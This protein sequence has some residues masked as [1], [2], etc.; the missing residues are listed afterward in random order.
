MQLQMNKSYD[1]KIKECK[2]RIG[3]K[4]ILYII[5]VVIGVCLFW[6][7][8]MLFFTSS[9][10]SEWREVIPTIEGGGSMN[11]TTSTFNISA[12]KWLLYWEPREPNPNHKCFVEIFNASTDEKLGELTLATN[13]QL[14][15]VF[16]EELQIRGSFY[17]K[18]QIM[19]TRGWQI[20]VFEYSPQPDW[21]AWIVVIGIAL[22]A[23][24]VG[25]QTFRVMTA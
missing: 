25:Y 6:V 17:L 23:V 2:K 5:V 18:I 8:S 14:V 10:S 4:K 7:V 20:K 24:F 16:S 3:M 1:N 15:R 21:L 19:S 9:P 13:W 22:V 12:E 11:H